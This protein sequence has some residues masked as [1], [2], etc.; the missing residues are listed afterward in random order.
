MTREESKVVGHTRFDAR[1]RTISRRG[2]RVRLTADELVS[3]VYLWLP[4]DQQNIELV[5]ST[6]EHAVL[7]R[8]GHPDRLGQGGSDPILNLT[9]IL[10]LALFLY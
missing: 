4:P 5:V 8:I 6:D 1:W 2:W 10:T 7:H 9:R 3:R